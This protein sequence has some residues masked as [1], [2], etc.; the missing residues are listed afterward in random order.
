VS[1][2]TAELEAPRTPSRHLER[3]DTLRGELALFHRGLADLC[4]ANVPLPRA[5]RILHVDL[6]RGPMARE[7]VRMAEEIEQGVPLTEAYG[8]RGTHFSP[9]YRALVEAGVAGGGALPDVL[10]EIATHASQRQRINERMRGAL[11][12]PLVA[13]GFVVVIGA[14]L[15]LFVAPL[16]QTVQSQGFGVDQGRS[17]G[18]SAWSGA[19]LAVLLVGILFT[20]ALLRRPIDEGAGPR[21]LAFRLP[22]LGRMRLYATK[23]SF[24]GTLALLL[25]RETPLPQALKITADATDDPEVRARV[26]R[27]AEAAE[28]GAGL[29]ESIGSGALVSP[30]LAWFLEAASNERSAAEALEDIAAIYRQRLER[31]ADRVAVLAAPVAQVLIGIVV[32]GFAL[33]YMSSAFRLGGAPS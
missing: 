18:W 31:A 22:L 17:P 29:P 13:A 27:M 32:L 7:A 5:L 20:W 24:A 25:R 2:A 15:T 30:S 4:R 21:S 8:A 14:L 1:S 19:G 26:Q 12:Y 3:G 33:S 11:A 23:A 10:D 9:V 6:E 28:A 16:D